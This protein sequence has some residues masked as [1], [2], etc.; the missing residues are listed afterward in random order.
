VSEPRDDVAAGPP[1]ISFRPADAAPA[2]A[3]PPSLEF[4]PQDA[5]VF[6]ED[7]R[8]DHHKRVVGLLV[9]DKLKLVKITAGYRAAIDV[10]CEAALVDASGPVAPRF[11]TREALLFWAEPRL[12]QGVRKTIV[13]RVGTVL[14]IVRVTGDESAPAIEVLASVDAR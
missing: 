3:S 1:A 2:A 14:K 7:E 12:P 8:A 13:L 5:L 9:D 10:I 4:V 6:W 11:I